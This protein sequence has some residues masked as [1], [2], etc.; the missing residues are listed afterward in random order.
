MLNYQG[1]EHHKQTSN[2]AEQNIISTSRNNTLTQNVLH[3]EIGTA[4]GSHVSS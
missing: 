2:W 1:Y 4:E 3:R